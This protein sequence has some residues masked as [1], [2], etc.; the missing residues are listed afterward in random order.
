MS[1]NVILNFVQDESRIKFLNFDPED[2]QFEMTWEG[3]GEYV[4]ERSESK[5]FT[6]PYFALEVR[7]ERPENNIFLAKDN[8]AQAGKRYYYR[9]YY[10]DVRGKR[11]YSIKVKGE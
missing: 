1:T 9:T 4:Y 7:N 5:N 3:P 2:V 6:E 8:T 10:N 11:I